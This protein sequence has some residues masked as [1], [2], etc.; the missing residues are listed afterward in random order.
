MSCGA[1]LVSYTTR[2]APVATAGSHCW[3]VSVRHCCSITTAHSCNTTHVARVTDL[4]RERPVL[5]LL[6]LYRGALLQHNTFSEY[7]ENFRN[8]SFHL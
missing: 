3:L 5:A 1:H 8:I 4:L 2:H 7:C 6:L